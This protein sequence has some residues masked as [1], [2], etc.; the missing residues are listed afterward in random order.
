MRNNQLQIPATVSQHQLQH[1][2]N[3]FMQHVQSIGPTYIHTNV[4][5]TNKRWTQTQSNYTNTKLKAWFR[6][7]L[8]HL[9]R[10]RT[11]PILQSRTHTGETWQEPTRSE[12][13][14]VVGRS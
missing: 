2:C 10:K 3:G 7:L 13:V 1:V 8:H 6:R 12:E 11:G 5:L 14:S 4:I 9:A